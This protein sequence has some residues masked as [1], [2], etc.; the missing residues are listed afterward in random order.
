[1]IILSLDL[2]NP[3]IR[4]QETGAKDKTRAEGRYHHSLAETGRPERHV[5]EDDGEHSCQADGLHPPRRQAGGP[6]PLQ[7]LRVRVQVVRAF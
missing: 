3:Q 4:S 6:P 1:M 5:E 2:G 7:A